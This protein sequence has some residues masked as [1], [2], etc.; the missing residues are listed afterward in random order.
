M[1]FIVGLAPLAVAGFLVSLMLPY[2]VMVDHLNVT[3]A[4]TH[5]EKKLW[6]R[7][8]WWNHRSLVAVWAYLFAADR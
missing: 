1:G 5:E 4:L 2:G 6:C 3:R 7:E 8:L